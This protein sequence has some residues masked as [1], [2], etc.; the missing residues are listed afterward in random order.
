MLTWGK[1]SK[2]GGEDGGGFFYF[3]S[4]KDSGSAALSAE[5]VFFGEGA[6]GIQGFVDLV[7]L[8][9]GVG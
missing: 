9:L 8:A 6:L 2:Q 4:E 7:M 3:H 5:R 1:G